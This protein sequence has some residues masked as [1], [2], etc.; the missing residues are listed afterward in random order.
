MD[1][2][3]GV[4]KES[5]G[6]A[7]GDDHPHVRTMDP[8]I[9]VVRLLSA[10]V[11]LL[12]VLVLGM[13]VTAAV[14]LRAAAAADARRRE[15]LAQLTATSTA[16]RQ[17]LARFEQ[18]KQAISGDPGGPLGRMDRQIQLMSIM[19]DEQMVLV[20]EVAALHEAAAHALGAESPSGRAQARAPARNRR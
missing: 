3:V 12:V 10:I 19:V 7:P 9:K 8:R 4:A 2:Q 11:V 15:A 17:A 18:Q 13:G 16:A 20:S 1:P 5:P 6:V 14:S